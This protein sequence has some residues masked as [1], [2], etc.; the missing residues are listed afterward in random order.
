M[1]W[2]HVVEDESPQPPNPRVWSLCKIGLF[3]FIIIIILLVKNL[4]QSWSQLFNQPTPNQPPPPPPPVS[5]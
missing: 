4:R 5:T 1:N 2:T 3:L